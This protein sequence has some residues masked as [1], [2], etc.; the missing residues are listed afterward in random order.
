M[1]D[2]DMPDT[3]SQ[4]LARAHTF[5]CA[6][7]TEH[8]VRQCASRMLAPNRP[9]SPAMWVQRLEDRAA[10]FVDGAHGPMFIPLDDEQAE[11]VAAVL[12]V[13]GG[14]V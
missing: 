10:L 5:W 3:V 4:L 12:N 6:L 8:D 13:V 9:P 14:F 11:R 7:G 2:V 1:N